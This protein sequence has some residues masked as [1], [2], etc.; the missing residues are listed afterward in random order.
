MPQIPTTPHLFLFAVAA[1]AQRQGGS[2]CA[3]QSVSVLTHRNNPSRTGANLSETCLTP[4]N[5]RSS[6]GKLFSLNVQ[7]QV[8]AQ[9][10]IV[11]DLQ[12][13]GKKRNVLFVATMENWVYAFD[14]DG[15]LETNG[16]REMFWKKS[17]GP[18]LPSN[19]IPRDVGAFLGR[20]NV[21]P[22]IGVTSTPVIDPATQTIFL[23]AKVAEIKDETVPCDG[24]VAT[25]DCPVANKIFAL[26]IL[27][28]HIRDSQV[29]D[30]KG[31][32]PEPTQVGKPCFPW[33]A[34]R[35][36]S[37][38]DAGRINLQRTALL[39]NRGRIYMGF[40]SH[41]DAPCPMYHGMLVAFDFDPVNLKLS[42][43]AKPFLV[44]KLGETDSSPNLDPKTLGK[45]G[46][47]Q[48]GNGPA[49]DDAGNVYVMTG[50]GG[51][52]KDVQFSSS[53]LKLSPD[54]DKVEWFAPANVGA[55]NADALDIDLGS[56]GPVLLPGAGTDQVMGA[57]KQ[58]MLYLVKPSAMGGQQQHRW[59]HDRTDPPI[60]YF[61]AAKRW[62]PEF[63]YHVFPISLFAFATG[64]HHIHGAPAFW[65]DL[66]DGKLLRG[67]M[68]VWPERDYVKAF[69]WSR[70]TSP[71]GKFDPK[72]KKIGPKAGLGMPGG[73]LS[74]SSHNQDNG[75]LWAALPLH[76]DAWVDIVRGALRAFEITPDGQTLTPVWTSYCAE[77]NDNFN[78]AKYVPPTVANGKVY[79]ATFSNLVNVYGLRPSGSP[80][81]TDWKP[82]CDPTALMEM[83]SYKKTAKGVKGHAH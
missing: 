23:V 76:D 50:N 68:Y 74:I 9:P 6:F 49:A 82:D 48:A 64:Y 66:R 22:S 75:I 38:D 71:D 63:I 73:F 60:Q 7:G 30:M 79:L 3:P 54:L 80:Q 40:G 47:W 31:Y 56:S 45:G 18:A 21:S 27:N 24:Q 41:Q 8:Y 34:K 17:L 39:W 2:G 4:T 43:F 46:I 52:E 10:L 29:I 53:L 26:N 13:R 72:P 33:D 62:A 11:A 14:A 51:F 36:V 35:N 32:S 65:P 44:T 42:Q 5:V 58:G 37:R 19:R 15:H 12:I 78:F 25:A 59:P 83:P 77:P 57:G 20:Y 69:A 70:D 61:W 67:V 55:L 28:G 1:L 81:S 16:D